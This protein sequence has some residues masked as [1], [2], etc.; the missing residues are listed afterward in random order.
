MASVG[1]MQSCTECKVEAIEKNQ[2][3][4]HLLE[5]SAGYI[6]ETG[7]LLAKEGEKI[8]YE[9]Q[10]NENSHQKEHNVAVTEEVGTV[11]DGLDAV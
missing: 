10:K 4:K 1:K 6:V 9:R 5:E 7:A 3:K 11:A 2:S 8:E